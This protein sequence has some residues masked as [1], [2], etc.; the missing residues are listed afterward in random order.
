MSAGRLISNTNAKTS[1]DICTGSILNI[2]IKSLK[3]EIVLSNIL[4]VREPVPLK[5]NFFYS[6]NS[7]CRLLNLSQ[8]PSA[9]S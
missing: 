6:F 5:A 3:I 9:G 7:L 8:Q 1:F 2:I 4:I